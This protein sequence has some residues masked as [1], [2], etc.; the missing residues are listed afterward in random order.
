M[1]TIIVSASIIKNFKETKINVYIITFNRTYD[2][3]TGILLVTDFAIA[4]L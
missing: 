2:S 3:T 4:Q 1:T